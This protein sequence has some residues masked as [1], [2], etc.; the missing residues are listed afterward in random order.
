MPKHAHPS[1]GRRQLLRYAGASLILS[2]TPL[3]GAA[4]KLPSVLAV[5][6][7]PAA[8]YTRVTLEHDAPL[9]F[10][11]FTVENPD[12]LVVDIEGV[13]FNS[14]LDSLARKLT[15]DD[16]NIKLLRAGR[17]KPGVVRLVMEL[18]GKVNPQVFTLE[19]AG[20]YGR[21]LVLDVYPVNPP[22]PM[23]AL[24][25]GRKDAVEPLKNEQDFQIVE[26]RPDD[27]A[28]KKAEKAPIEA[29]EVHTSK[30]SGAHRCRAE[31]ARRA[32]P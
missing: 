7:W 29:P 28:A 8:D 16:P 9:K 20:E 30:K 10:T 25:E 24:L 5:R 6:I 14:V 2:V 12:R 1:H 3:A 21:R 23:M 31:H 18:K 17:F 15:T 13:E 19:P 32:D 27:V 22:D 26:K 4:A 11:H